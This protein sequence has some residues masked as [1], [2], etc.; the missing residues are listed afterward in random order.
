MTQPQKTVMSHDGLV[1]GPTLSWGMPGKGLGL[2]DLHP[3][4]GVFKLQINFIELF[5]RM[6]ETF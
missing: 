6:F 1:T 2:K 4:C 5:I 3:P